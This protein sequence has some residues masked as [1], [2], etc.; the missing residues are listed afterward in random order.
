MISFPSDILT[1]QMIIKVLRSSYGR[2]EGEQGHAEILNGSMGQQA[3]RRIFNLYENHFGESINFYGRWYKQHLSLVGN[4]NVYSG[5]TPL[6]S[7]AC[8][9]SGDIVNNNNTE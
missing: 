3:S 5:N 4:L 7:I 8:N 9:A 6:G 1:S 2:G